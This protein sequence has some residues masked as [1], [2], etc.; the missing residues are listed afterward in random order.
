MFNLPDNF[1]LKI[2]P[3]GNSKSEKDSHSHGP[4]QVLS[5]V[6]SSVGGILSTSNPC[7]LPR[8]EQQVADVKRRQ[9]KSSFGIPSACSN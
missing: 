7:S 5:D 9:K 6:S 4:K 2:K 8:N 1:D 3:H